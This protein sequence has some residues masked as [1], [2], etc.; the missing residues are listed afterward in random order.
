LYIPITAKATFFWRFS[1]VECRWV[2]VVSLL[3]SA[4]ES[5]QLSE[6]GYDA[7]RLV[8]YLIMLDEATVSANTVDGC[9][10]RTCLELIV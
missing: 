7:W 6:D 9:D 3:D 5:G 8:L 4:I 2:T 1:N 10:L